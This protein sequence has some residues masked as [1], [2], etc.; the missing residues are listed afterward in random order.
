MAM[1]LAIDTTTAQ[2]YEEY[3][4]E[5][6]NTFT[7]NAGEIIQTDANGLLD[8]S[9]LPSSVINGYDWKESV[10]VA[11]QGNINLASPGATIDGETMTVGDRF[12]APAQTAGAENGIYVWNGAAVAATRAPDADEDSEVTS[13]NRVYIESGTNAQNVATLVTN[14]PITV[15]TTAQTF[16]FHK[17]NSV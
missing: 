15:G 7:G 17:N 6:T 1:I 5:S 2:D 8:V 14:D 16:V 10:L 11:A 12:L 9:F 4:I 3:C 13:G